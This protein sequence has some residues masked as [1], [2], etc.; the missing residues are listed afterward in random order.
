MAQFTT[1]T[2]KSP[3]GRLLI[4][5]LSNHSQCFFPDGKGTHSE[6]LP[7]WNSISVTIYGLLACI[8]HYD[9]I[10]SIASIQDNK[11]SLKYRTGV[12]KLIK[13]FLPLRYI[14]LSKSYW[15]S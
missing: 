6:H 5:D 9:I 7:S 14:L 15:P 3:R 4:F 2:S 12:F 1:D 13:F 8:Y 10:E 11:F